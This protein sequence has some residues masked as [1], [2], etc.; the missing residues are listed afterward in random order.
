[1]LEVIS[2]VQLHIR[3][4]LPNIDGGMDPRTGT[5][6]D[7]NCRNSRLMSSSSSRHTHQKST[8]SH[9]ERLP[10]TYPNDVPMTS[11]APPIQKMMSTLEASKT[12]A[13]R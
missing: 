9:T 1:M 7:H 10:C 2:I 13:V 12:G 3:V 4:C 5:N 11:T 8:P 6:R